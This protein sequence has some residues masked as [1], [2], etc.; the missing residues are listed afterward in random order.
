SGN[1]HSL[2]FPISPQMRRR[3][4]PEPDDADSDHSGAKLCLDR[5]GDLLNVLP[6][7]TDVLKTLSACFAFNG[8]IA[9]VADLIECIEKVAPIHFTRSSRHFFA[10]GARLLRPRCILDMTLTQP[11]RQ[12]S[13]GF[14]RIA[15]VVE[16]HV[17]R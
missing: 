14:N 5:G 1:P 7:S 12:G 8:T 2:Y 3:H 16:N 13:Q 17:R 15:F 10:P 11:G 6:A 4:E 9:A